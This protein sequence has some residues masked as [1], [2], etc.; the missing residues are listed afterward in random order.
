M[1]VAVKAL[2]R[3]AS[4]IDNLLV[5]LMHHRNELPV[6]QLESNTYLCLLWACVGF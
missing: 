3:K 6:S 1:E 2:G 5:E 4:G